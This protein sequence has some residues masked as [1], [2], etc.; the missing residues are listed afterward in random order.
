MQSQNSRIPE[1]LK[2]HDTVN[3][4]L[5]MCINIHFLSDTEISEVWTV[6]DR[7]LKIPIYQFDPLFLLH[8]TIFRAD[9]TQKYL[10]I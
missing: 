6:L 5:S 2:N 7:R 1:N 8:A 4:C 9:T 3:S 10:L